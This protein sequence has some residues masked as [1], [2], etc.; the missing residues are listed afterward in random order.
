MIGEQESTTTVEVPERMMREA[1]RIAQQQHWTISEAVVYLVNRGIEAQSE[2]ERTI[3][4]AY[5]VFMNAPQEKKEEVG[6]ELIQSIFG[7]TFEV[8]PWAETTSLDT[9]Y[10]ST[11]NDCLGYGLPL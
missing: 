1:K 7:Q 6:K 4:Q 8:G 5:Q 2:T 3:T 10:H 11:K 9:D